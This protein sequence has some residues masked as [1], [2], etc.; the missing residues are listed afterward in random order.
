MGEDKKKTI[1]TY[2]QMAENALFL[3]THLNPT[4]YPFGSLPQGLSVPQKAETKTTLVHRRLLA[5]TIYMS[6]SWQH[7]MFHQSKLLLLHSSFFSKI[8]RKKI[9]S[10]LF[11]LHLLFFC[12]SLIIQEREFKCF[13]DPRYNMV[14]GKADLIKWYNCK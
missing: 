3:S 6:L 10:W 7:F 13:S 1:N 9:L 8:L 11:S 12:P 2:K 5:P 14:L 4:H